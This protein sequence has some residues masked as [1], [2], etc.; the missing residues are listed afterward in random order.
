[1]GTWGWRRKAVV[2]A[3]A[4]GGL[5]A[6]ACGG[7]DD[8]GDRSD[9]GDEDVGDGASTTVATVAPA[10]A[11]PEAAP[12][13]PVTVTGADGDEVTVRDVSRIIPA[14]GDIAE[15]VFALGLGADVVATDLS[16]TY[17]PEADALPEVGYQRSLLVEP[18]LGHD[19]TVVVANTDA[20]PDDSLDQLRDAGVPVVV[21]DYPHDLTGPAAKIRL[22]AQA[23]GVPARGEAL[24]REVD[25]AIAG[26]VADAEARVEA[27]GGERPRV[28]FLYLRGDSV[29][30][31]GGR[32]SRADALIEAAGAVDVGVELGLDDFEPLSEEALVRAAPDVFLVTTTGIESVGGVDAFLE[33]PAIAQTPAGRDRRVVAVD[34]QLLLGLGPRT[35]DALAQ[36]VTELHPASHETGEPDP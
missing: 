4:L 31:L 21:L 34:D 10:G 33:L 9:R 12:E 27:A 23:L 15:V 5:V 29:Q 7:G 20:G 3:L 24:A 18:M 11:P 14:N 30:Q 32:G 8:D 13:L 2:G 28:A 35:G 25:A 16:A 19:P 17:P 22:V 6:A 26:A 36:L 1:M